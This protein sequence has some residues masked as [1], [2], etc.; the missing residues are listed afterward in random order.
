MLDPHAELLRINARIKEI[1]LQHMPRTGTYHSPVPGLVTRRLET[2]HTPTTC[3]GKPSASIIV[4][5]EKIAMLGDR[6]IHY[7]EGQCLVTGVDMP[8]AFRVLQ[9]CHDHPFLAMSL[10][11][12]R[13]LTGQMVKELADAVPPA[14][15]PDSGVI[16][17]T[18]SPELLDA[19][20]RLARLLDTPERIPILAPLVIREIHY[21]LLI[22]P[23]GA[24]LRQLNTHGTQ[25]N[26]IAQATDWLRKNYR[27]P[28]LVSQLAR[29]VNMGT[30]TFHRH[31]KEVT[32][33]SPLQYH[34]RLRL[35]E[36]QRLML[37]GEMDAGSAGLA[38]GYEST[39]QFNR[40]YKR[41]FGEPPLRDLKRMRRHDA[42]PSENSH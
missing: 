39:A 4:Q 38:V 23:Q 26:S 20:L 32:G 18:T 5:G 40:E 28:L 1:L 30:S 31:F 17:G 13:S 9:A 3:L 21:L 6:E 33:M 41:L 14:A 8:N 22:G 11:L 25:A 24:G 37:A 27:K 7:G 2:C 34:K 42:C 12:D 35:Y 19:F 10:E 36:A 15:R 16:L 29:Q